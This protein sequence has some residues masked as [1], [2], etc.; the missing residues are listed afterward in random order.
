MTPDPF[1]PPRRL[2]IGPEYQ[3]TGDRNELVKAV[4]YALYCSKIC[5]YAQG[6]QLMRAAETEYGWKLD[7][8]SIASIWRG[9]CIIRA[10]FLQKITDAYSRDPRLVNLLLDPYF[11]EQIQKNQTRCVLS[12]RSQLKRASP[13]PRSCQLWRITTAIGP[14]NFRQ[15]S[16]RPNGTISA[17]TPTN[18]SINHDV[19]RSISIGPN[20]TVLRSELP[21]P[22]KKG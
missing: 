18:V 15:T 1:S 17:P 21:I 6:F 5:A 12:W 13:L 10:R 3:Y 9:G 8:A 20:Q 16:Y 2:L 19:Y 7:L 14:H 4:H 11:K 22:I